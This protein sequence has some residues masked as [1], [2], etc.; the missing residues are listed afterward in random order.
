MLSWPLVYHGVHRSGDESDGA[1][2]AVRFRGLYGGTERLEVETVSTVRVGCPSAGGTRETAVGVHCIVIGRG[3]RRDAA[4]IDGGNEEAVA[5]VSARRRC[6][7]C[8]VDAK[9]RPWW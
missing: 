3:R 5:M 8:L 7:V 2:I 9:K 4:T 1:T 6:K